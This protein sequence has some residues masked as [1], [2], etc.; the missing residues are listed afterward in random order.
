MGQLERIREIA[1][2]ELRWSNEYWEKEVE[3]YQ[4]IWNDFYSPV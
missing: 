4:A 3:R 2:P 1:Q